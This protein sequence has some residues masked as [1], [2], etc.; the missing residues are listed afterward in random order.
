MVYNQKTA[1]QS[2]F[3]LLELYFIVLAIFSISYDNIV[4]TDVTAE[5]TTTSHHF[6]TV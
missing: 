5:N 4:L 2:Q 6:N 3:T 1:V